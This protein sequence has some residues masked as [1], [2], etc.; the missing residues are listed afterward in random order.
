MIQI[1]RDIIWKHLPPEGQRHDPL[2]ALARLLLDAEDGRLQSARAY[3]RAWRRSREFVSARFEE[4]RLATLVPDH[5]PGHETPA[6]PE[7]SVPLARAAFTATKP[8]NFTLSS[9][10]TKRRRRQLTQTPAPDDL[11]GDQWTRLREWMDSHKREDIRALLPERH[12][13]TASCLTWHR[14]KGTL[15]ANWLAAVEQWILREP[16]SRRKAG[17]PAVAEDP[18][19]VKSLEDHERQ[20]YDG[21]R[22]RIDGMDL[23]SLH[24][25]LERFNEASPDESQ[26]RWKARMLLEKTIVNREETAV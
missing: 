8:S 1:P 23:D 14:H 18:Q 9:E 19:T 11:S 16:K 20:S 15:G 21:L 13:L 6:T 2:Q 10:P 17:V 4:Y 26:W 5:P 12:D 22:A 24:A 3:T 25:Q 7:A